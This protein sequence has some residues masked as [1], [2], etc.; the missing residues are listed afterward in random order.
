MSEE[1]TKGL[2]V[3]KIIATK[4]YPNTQDSKRNQIVWYK[5]DSF[6][7]GK[8]YNEFLVES[9]KKASKKLTGNEGVP[10]FCIVSD[11]HDVMI[12]VECK[13]S[14]KNHQKYSALLDYKKGLSDVDIEKYAVDGAL[15]YATFLKEKYDVIAIA[16]S[17]TVESNIRMTSF[18]FPKNA[19]F[20]DIQLIENGDFGNTFMPLA[21]Y[22]KKIDKILK[23]HQEKYSKIESNL[24]SYAKAC[25]NF[26]RD[27]GISA[28]DRAGF[29]SAVVLALTN[30]DD[31]L[32]LSVENDIKL[33]KYADSIQRNAIA[34]LQSSLENIWS[35]I[36]KIPQ[37]KQKVLEEYY[38][39]ILT[40]ALLEPAE[41]K[42]KYFEQ[43]SN[44]LTCCIY[45]V[46]NNIIALLKPYSEL[47]IMGIFYTIFLKYAKGDAKDKGIVLTPKHITDLFCDI[48]EYY[49]NQKIDENIK[50]L[51]TCCG[52][53]G[54]LI[55]ALNRIDQNVN[56]QT[57]SDVEKTK[58][59]KAARENSLIG[60]EKEPE[61]FALAY[62]NMRF[63]GDGKSNLFAC[64]S[65]IKD[66]GN[67]KGVAT[68]N[69]NGKPIPLKQLLKRKK[70]QC[71]V[72]MINPPYS[73]KSKT[74]KQD[75]GQKQAKQTELDFVY[76][77]LSYLK[78][79]GIGI[80]LVPMS[81][82]SNKGKTMRKIILEEHTLLA[83]MTMPK[84]LFQNSDVGTSTCI[85]VFKAGIPHRDSS[86]SVFL[87][88]WLDDGFVTVPHSGRYD[89]N[90]MWTY[91]KSEWLSQLKGDIITNET[92]FM[93][94]ELDE[95]DECLA[96]AY[97][98]TDYSKLSQKDFEN[99]LKKYSLFL[100]MQKNNLLDI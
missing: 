32:Y 6:K 56:S 36:D 62:A 46:Y 12:V 47:D 16:F 43:G 31:P 74:S 1:I 25:A 92:I 98:Q 19:G 7:K 8:N 93:K 100:Y 17:G 13:E 33:G 84:Q 35:T 20:E 86:K 3:K 80:A 94:K 69:S 52:T 34:S 85:M 53:G 97:V 89:K 57:I 48:A 59:K 73:L 77:M 71:D 90:N 22:Q 83:C 28:K 58:R 78:K 54:F 5:E 55:G 11:E 45:S 14:V 65:L 75:K 9:F 88:R 38:N 95:E 68:I 41:S 27:N 72:G 66:Q 26:L 30:N 87:A 40:S 99:E 81:S 61:M 49:L 15:H 82:A 96:E 51:D 21:D 23:R 50:I 39:R 44:V 29:I 76:S 42:G 60:I 64:S 79:G 4:N 37:D 70:M 91:I 67:P 63:H 2:F 10:D 18:L 24:K